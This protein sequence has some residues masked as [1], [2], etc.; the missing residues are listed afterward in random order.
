VSSQIEAQWDI[1]AGFLLAVSFTVDTKGHEWETEN[2]LRDIWVPPT[3]SLSPAHTR[4]H[5]II[6]LG[7][8]YRMQ[9]RDLDDFGIFELKGKSKPKEE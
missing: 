8:P 6:T 3:L 2:E 9:T 4:P 5:N 1:T 7:V